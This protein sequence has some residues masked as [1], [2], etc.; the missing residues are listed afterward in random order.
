M[1]TGYLQA[2]ET[3]V[4][5]DM[6]VA[7]GG[8]KPSPSPCKES[9][10]RVAVWRLLSKARVFQ[11]VK[12]EPRGTESPVV[13]QV[14]AGIPETQTSLRALQGSTANAIKENTTRAPPP[15]STPFLPTMKTEPALPL[16]LMLRREMESRQS[17]TFLLLVTRSLWV[18]VSR[19]FKA[20]ART[21]S[22]QPGTEALG[23]QSQ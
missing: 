6:R 14:A 22:S 19:A 1:E 13:S 20:E 7:A 2:T 21:L 4:A 9:P 12:L 17:W 3:C 10:E 23:S 5:C 16:S 11:M 15:P 8:V 18:P